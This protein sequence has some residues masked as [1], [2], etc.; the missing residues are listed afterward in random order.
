MNGHNAPLGNVGTAIG[1]LVAGVALLG[2]VVLGP[3]GVAALSTSDPAANG[4][5]AWKGAPGYTSLLYV[6]SAVGSL[7]LSAVSLVLLLSDGRRALQWLRAGVGLFGAS[8]LVLVAHIGLIVVTYGDGLDANQWLG[9]GAVLG[10]C[11]LLMAASLWVAGRT[12]SRD[13]KAGAAPGGE[14]HPQA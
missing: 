9:L 3:D 1:V 8:I 14:P 6:T 11:A 13:E 7:V 12:A 2:F 5:M 4:M 10:L